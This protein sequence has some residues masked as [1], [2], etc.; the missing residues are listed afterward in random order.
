MAE[1]YCRWDPMTKVVSLRF[2][3]VMALEDFKDFEGWQHD[4]KLRKWKC[5]TRSPPRTR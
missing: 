2:S 5:V 3:N 1:E 4:P